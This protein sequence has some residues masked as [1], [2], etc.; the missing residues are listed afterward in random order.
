VVPAV[1]GAE[2]SRRPE[3][4][5][6]EVRRLADAGRSEITL[7]G[8]RVNSYRHEAD[9]GTVRLAGLLERVASVAGVRRLRFLTSHPTGFTDDILRAMRDLPNVCEYLHVPAQSGSDPVLRRMNRGYTRGEY[10]ALIDRARDTVPG[11][12]LAGDFIVG[13]PGETDADH[14]ASA[15][16][17]RRSGYKNC[18]VFRYSPRPG[19]TAAVRMEDD[20]AAEVKARR[21][22]ELLAVQDEVGLAHHRGYIGRTVEVLVEGVSPR[23]DRQPRPAPAGQMQLTGRTRGDHIAVFDGPES[24]AGEYVNVEVVDAD[25][26]TLFARRVGHG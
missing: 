23:A 14:A 24:L 17:I 8:Q 13:F 12:A 16:L 21:N 19:T 15:E 4:V 2:R 6:E 10:D 3:A 1:R 22:R 25:A 11:I 7:L 5:V 20:V 18:F 9:G 26:R